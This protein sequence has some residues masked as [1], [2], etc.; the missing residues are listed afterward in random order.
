MASDEMAQN[1][2][3]WA[4]PYLEGREREEDQLTIPVKRFTCCSPVHNHNGSIA[5]VIAALVHIDNEVVDAIRIGH[6]RPAGAVQ[7][8]DAQLVIILYGL[9]DK[10]ATHIV[11]LVGL[12]KEF[13]AIIIAFDGRGLVRPELRKVL[14]EKRRK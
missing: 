4:P 8:L 14:Q 12:V 1:V 11:A 7:H 5:I 6:L 10:I 13:H 9:Y 3:A 2:H